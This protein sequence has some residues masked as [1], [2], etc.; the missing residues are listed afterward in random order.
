MKEFS[1]KKPAFSL[2]RFVYEY[3]YTSTVRHDIL[4]YICMFFYPSCIP[5]LCL[6][7]HSQNAYCT[8]SYRPVHTYVCVL[9]YT[10]PTYF[11]QLS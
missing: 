8:E 11:T 10:L 2:E 5:K 3:I 7:L 6:A 4:M 9:L 1:H